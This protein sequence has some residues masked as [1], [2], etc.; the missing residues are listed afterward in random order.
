MSA[1]DWDSPNE[2]QNSEDGMEHSPERGTR[3]VGRGSSCS[4]TDGSVTGGDR[5]ARDG[6]CVDSRRG[7]KS[8]NV[9]KTSRKIL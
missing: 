5:A 8:E 3:G 2:S 6:A 7:G 4:M 1:V 9:Y